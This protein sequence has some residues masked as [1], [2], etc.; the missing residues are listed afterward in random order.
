MRPVVA[1]VAGENAGMTLLHSTLRR[2][3]LWAAHRAA[4]LLPSDRSDWAQAMVR[5]TELIENDVSA[6]S[7]AIGAI[8]AGCKERIRTM[9]L[10]EQI[11][12]ASGAAPVVLSLLALG[13]AL[14]A[15]LSGAERGA[16]DEGALAHIFQLLIVAELPIIAVFLGTANWK[17]IGSIVRP[18]ALQA[19]GVMLAFGAVAY[20]N[21]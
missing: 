13:I 7:W 2:T 8:F 14:F 11:N 10:R 4:Q 18:L 19:G 20:F 6:L 5:E 15:G 9:A 3:A 1:Q 16:T 21:L 12:G 17:R